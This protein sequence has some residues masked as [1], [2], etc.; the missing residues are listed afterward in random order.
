MGSLSDVH[1]IC[2]R[3]MI[4][5]LLEQISI[6]RNECLFSGCNRHGR[7][8]WV[9]L[10]VFWPRA[11]YAKDWSPPFSTRDTCKARHKLRRFCFLHA[12]LFP[13]TKSTQDRRNVRWCATGWKLAANRVFIQPQEIKPI[14][15]WRLQF[16]TVSVMCGLLRPSCD[17]SCCAFPISWHFQVTWS[18]TCSALGRMEFRE[19]RRTNRFSSSESAHYW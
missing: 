8:T 9:G 19:R 18:Q 3:K 4:Q 12:I 15:H 2:A 1:I 5:K 14:W 17:W 6:L 13:G 10:S 11:R 16:L 7:K